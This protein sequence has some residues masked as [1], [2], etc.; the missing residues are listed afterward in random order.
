MVAKSVEEAMAKNAPQQPAQLTEEQWA[1]KEAEVGVPRG[2]I[3]FFTGQAMKVYNTLMQQMEAR[4][5]KFEKADQLRALSRAKGYEDAMRYPKFV[6]QFL[7]KYKPE[8]HANPELLKMAVVYARG[9]AS[10]ANV[11]RARVEAER[12]RRISGVARPSSPGSSAG[13]SR[14]PGA[15]ALRPLST[16]QKQAA[17]MMPGGEAEYRKWM[18][19]NNRVAGV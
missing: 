3:Q 6:E 11:Q 2:A 5:A 10:K 18:A 14:K 12:G 15:P 9:M 1:A 17:A 19:K 7:S 4:F 13:A 16:A 8:H